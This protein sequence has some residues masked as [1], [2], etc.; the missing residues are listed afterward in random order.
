VRDRDNREGDVQMDGE[1]INT[2]RICTCIYKDINILFR[3]H[4]HSAYRFLVMCEHTCHLPSNDI[5][6]SYCIIV[7]TRNDLHTPTTHT[8]FLLNIL[9]LFII[10]V[11]LSCSL[12]LCLSVCISLVQTHAY[13]PEAPLLDIKYW[14]QCFCVL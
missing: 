13:T 12:S 8:H 2:T 14:L 1:N 5:P 4:N 9:M 7:T 6:S 3:M 10:N 11:S